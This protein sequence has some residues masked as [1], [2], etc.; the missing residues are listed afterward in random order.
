MFPIWTA[1]TYRVE[2]SGTPILDAA[3]AMRR[4]REYVRTYD[5]WVVREDRGKIELR[6]DWV[7]FARRYRF[8]TMDMNAIRR[9]DIWVEDHG[10]VIAVHYRVSML[11]QILV[12]SLFVVIIFLD[13]AGRQPSMFPFPWVLYLMPAVLILGNRYFARRTLGDFIYRALWRP[14]PERSARER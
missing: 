8:A 12:A 1:G 4:I 6:Y 2:S 11:D 5:L 14:A 9:A 10:G 7:P 13:D 3:E